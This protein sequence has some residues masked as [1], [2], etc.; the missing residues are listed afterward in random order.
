MAPRA[1]LL[2]MSAWLS[3][4]IGGKAPLAEPKRNDF[5][6]ALSRRCHSP[7]VFEH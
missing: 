6:Q 3:R 7:L 2:K 4:I 5:A 1:E